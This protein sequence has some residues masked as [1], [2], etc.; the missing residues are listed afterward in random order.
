MLMALKIAFLEVSW[1]DFVDISLVAIL[2]YQI[3]KMIRGSL[4]VNIFL[5]I[6]SLYLIYLVVR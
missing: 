6:L 2:L 4:A 5:G 3:Y 1:V